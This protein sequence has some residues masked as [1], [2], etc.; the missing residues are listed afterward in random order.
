MELELIDSPASFIL[1]LL[2]PEVHLSYAVINTH[3]A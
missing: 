2:H 3:Q 1:V